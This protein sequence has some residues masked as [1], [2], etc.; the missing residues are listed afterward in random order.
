[1]AQSGWARQSGRAYENADGVWRIWDH[2]GNDHNKRLMLLHWAGQDL[3]TMSQPHVFRRFGG[4]APPLSLARMA[5]WL[6]R[7]YLVRNVILGAGRRG[8]PSAS[9]PRASPITADDAR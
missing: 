8:R 3:Q 2:G 9:A 1:M 7:S 5:G 4:C 6:R